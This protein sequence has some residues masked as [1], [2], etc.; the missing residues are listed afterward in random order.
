MTTPKSMNWLEKLFP[1]DSEEPKTS[2]LADRALEALRLVRDDHSFAMGNVQRVPSRFELRLSQEQYDMM[3]GMDALRDFTFFLKDELMKDLAN[4]GMRTFGDHTIRVAVESDAALG[5]NE[6][7][8]I[9]LNPDHGDARP[10]GEGEAPRARGGEGPARPK[11]PDSTLVLGEEEEEPAEDEAPTVTL[12]GDATAAQPER[13][14]KLTVRYP[15]ESNVERYLNGDR[16]IVGRRGRSGS[17]LPPNYHK[18]DLLLPS[19]ISREQIRLELDPASILVERL[20]KAAVRFEDGAVLG[21]GESRRI[22]FGQPF[23]I[24]GIEFRFGEA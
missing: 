9:V 7:Y 16:W 15:G 6:L 24:E 5:E 3:Q 12:S 13:T 4:E 23:F 10:A 8:A 14:Y 21:E 18:L 22:E 2:K 11:A 19:T 17:P 1:K 20:G